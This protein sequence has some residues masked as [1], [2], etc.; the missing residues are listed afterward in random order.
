MLQITHRVYVNR[1][2]IGMLK[3]WDA[4][5]IVN[6]YGMLEKE[7]VKGSVSVKI[8]EY[9]IRLLICVR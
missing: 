6:K 5:L 3:Q 9:G 1:F 4:K 7:L 8:I 2:S